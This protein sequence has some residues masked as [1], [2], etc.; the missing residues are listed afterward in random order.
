MNL[1]VV[2]NALSN[3]NNGDMYNTACACE[4][5]SV[6]AAQALVHGFIP[7]AGS[8]LTSNFSPGS[9]APAMGK[10]QI[11]N[12]PPDTAAVQQSRAF[13]VWSYLKR[14]FRPS[15]YVFAQDED[16]CYNF[17][18]D[19]DVYLIDASTQT[20]RKINTPGDASFYHDNNSPYAPGFKTGSNKANYP[21]SDTTFGFNYL[22]PQPLKPD[23]NLAIYYWG[24]LHQMWR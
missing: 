21:P 23:D 5:I 1:A 24:D 9:S 11:F 15:V 20:Y 13:Q 18:V 3:L 7:T 4:P 14:Q 19:G 16:H 22:S 17:V 8:G 12:L 6:L 2:A 10:N